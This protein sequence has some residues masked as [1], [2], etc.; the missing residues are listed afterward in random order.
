MPWEGKIL[1]EAKFGGL[2]VLMPWRDRIEQF[3]KPKAKDW[4]QAEY[5]DT[6][7]LRH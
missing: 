3:Q 1:R 2:A 6:W 7:K 5:P 4:T